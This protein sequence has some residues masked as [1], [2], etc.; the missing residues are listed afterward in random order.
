MQIQIPELSL[1][2]LVGA[3]SAG[4]S[5]FARR[6]FLPTEIVTSDFCRALVADDENDLSATEDA[7][8]VLHFIAGKRLQAGCQRSNGVAVRG[9]QPP[10]KRLY[11]LPATCLLLVRQCLGRRDRVLPGLRRRL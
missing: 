1:V 8:A 2:V 10:C 4:K 3:S 9:L 5:S 6:H 7:F 11:G